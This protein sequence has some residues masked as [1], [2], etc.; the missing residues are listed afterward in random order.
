MVLRSQSMNAI[1]HKLVKLNLI[2]QDSFNRAPVGISAADQPR[3]VKDKT[4]SNTVKE[5]GSTPVLHSKVRRGF[6]S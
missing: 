6:S 5:S 3:L 2:S 4:S 1:H